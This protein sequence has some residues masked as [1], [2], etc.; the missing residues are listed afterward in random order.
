MS[1]AIRN[2]VWGR[3]PAANWEKQFCIEL[4]GAFTMFLQSD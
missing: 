4:V 1:L 3:D 2:Q